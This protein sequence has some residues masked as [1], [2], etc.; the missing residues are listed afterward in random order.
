MEILI[1]PKPLLSRVLPHTI[2]VLFDQLGRY[3]LSGALVCVGS[4]RG[5]AVYFHPEGRDDE[6][7]RGT[8]GMF[9]A[10]GPAFTVGVVFPVNGARKQG[11][12]MAVNYSPADTYTV[13]LWRRVPGEVPEMLQRIPGVYGDSLCETV[14]SVYDDAIHRYNDGFIPLDDGEDDDDV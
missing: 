10:D 13:W 7:V 1:E 5:K 11:W 8:E 12:M 6:E 2:S 4:E 14:I 9:E 3:T